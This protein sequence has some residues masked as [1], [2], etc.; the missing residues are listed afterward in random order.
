MNV[1]APRLAMLGLALA[2][3]A[4]ALIGR[5]TVPDTSFHSQALSVAGWLLAL[6][7]LSARPA[8]AWAPG[9]TPR[10]AWAAAAALG[11]LALFA[12]PGWRAGTL[13]DA[14]VLGLA[15]AL[16]L[17][18][19]RQADPAWSLRALAWGLLAGAAWSVLVMLHQFLRPCEGDNLLI[20]LA[21]PGRVD[22][23]LRQPNLMASYLLLA[24]LL[25]AW[26]AAGA[27]RARPGLWAAAAAWLV[28]GVAL[29]ASR[30]GALALLIPVAWGLRDRGLPRPL[31]ALLIGL[32]LL[33]ALAFGALSL[34]APAS[35]P[36][37]CAA[38]VA[39]D[40]AR[41]EEGQAI[42]AQAL[43]E[44]P[45]PAA[46]APRAGLDPT[47]YRGL[48]RLLGGGDLSSGRLAIW[49]DAWELA[50]R[51]PWAGVGWARFNLAWFFE[52]GMARRTGHL[53]HAHLLPLQLAAELG[54][55]R[56][57]L[58]LGLLAGAG[59]VALRRARAD[60]APCS[61]RPLLLALLAMLLLHSLLELPLWWPMF[62]LPAAWWLG[63]ALRAE[64]APPD[65]TPAP[66]PAP[67]GPRALAAGVGMAG[68]IVLGLAGY[69]HRQ[70]EDLVAR[71]T[72][73]VE[74]AAL[75]QASDAF[76]F[77]GQH[78]D[79]LRVLQRGARPAPEDFAR[80]LPD[81]LNAK[82]ARAYILALH[83]AGH[84][85][86]ASFVAQRLRSFRTPE[87]QVMFLDCEQPDPP[88]PYR[89]R[90]EPLA[91]DW[92]ALPGI[93]PPP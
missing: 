86:E 18:G 77:Y 89:C 40:Q 49:H 8:T 73:S 14:G 23:N 26:L 42:V 44:T 5:P 47:A 87:V 56:A 29:T 21:R 75:L 19:A 11:L 38:V 13:V 63:L 52:D 41:A 31:R 67:R 39:R 72:V 2:V 3:L 32:P 28:L 74:R 79:R 17:L 93:A 54:F 50:R 25:G 92:Q 4:P 68:L 37:A 6:L 70:V 65:A 20:A 61:S 15:A 90:R 51:H 55:P 34:L 81:L 78:L 62:L 27:R 10:A 1:G 48:Q 7:A 46:S 69:E 85:A 12:L 35:L 59:W 76:R 66:A 36:P 30:T 88:A 60:A 45:A 53:T 84:E 83:R 16:V 71:P 80:V 9:P 58:V 24:G 22:G 91:L 64:T 43:D 33:Y 82:L 57:L